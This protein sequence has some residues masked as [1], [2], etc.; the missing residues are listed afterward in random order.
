MNPNWMMVRPARFSNST[1]KRRNHKRRMTHFGR[2]LIGQASLILSIGKS[3]HCVEPPSVR[4]VP[5]RVGAGISHS[6]NELLSVIEICVRES[7]GY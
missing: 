7:S 5:E 3:C 4:A 6:G 1:Q 2:T